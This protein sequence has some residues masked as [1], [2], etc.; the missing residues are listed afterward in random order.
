MD[1]DTL[2][3]PGPNEASSRRSKEARRLAAAASDRAQTDF[4]EEIVSTA[5]RIGAA[6][7]R[8]GAPI[9]RTDAVWRLICALERSHY[10]N[11][12]S[13]AARLLRITR[14]SAHE[15]ARQAERLRLVELAPNSRTV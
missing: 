6:K 4:L 10:C 3:R 7:S 15:L 8:A 11:A 12:I 13:D 2:S 1:R 14:Q 9:V 5:A